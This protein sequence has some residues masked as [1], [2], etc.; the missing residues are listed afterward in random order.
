[1]YPQNMAVIIIIT[2]T[3]TRLRLQIFTKIKKEIL[4]KNQ[5]LQI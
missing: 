1:M 5:S 3:F 2:T 4:K